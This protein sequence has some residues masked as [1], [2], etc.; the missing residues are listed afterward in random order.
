MAA[1]TGI[2][3]YGI[4]TGTVRIVLVL[5]AVA[6]VAIVVLVPWKTPIVRRGLGRKRD[7]SWLSIALAC[8]VVITITS[9]VAHSVFDAAEL[10]PVTVMQI[11]VTAAILAVVTVVVHMRQRPQR[12]RIADLDRRTFLRIAGLATA[13]VFGYAVVERGA[14]AAGL[15][16][17][18]RRFTGSHER[19]SYQ[20]TQMP[21]TSWF[22][23]STPQRR[24][25]AITVRSAGEDT[26]LEIDA[27][28][29]YDDRL[30]ATLDC[31]GGWFSTQE[32]SGVKLSR[33]IAPASGSV[34]VISA[35]GYERRFPAADVE[36]LL[37]ATHAG[38]E[39]LS[40]GHGAPVRLVAP[41][42]RGFWWV[43]WVTAIVVDDRPAWWQPPLP[44][45]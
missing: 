11:H 29:S 31:T 24:P 14:A 16:G 35:T 30:T 33:L 32:W 45:S 5:H 6:A 37:L 38:G 25:H 23:D 10:G 7:G 42:R 19:G 39:P 28:A 26:N 34:R 4:G 44:L 20:P 18:S 40:P 9:G 8:F 27:L 1:A 22:N 17:G 36:R 41:G 15:P 43:K 13:A 2:A 21:V 12:L 3:S